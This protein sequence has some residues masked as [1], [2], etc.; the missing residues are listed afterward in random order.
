[1]QKYWCISDKAVGWSENKLRRFEYKLIKAHSSLELGGFKVFY[2]NN[3]TKPL[4]HYSNLPFV[5]YSSHI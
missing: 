4:E 1:M 2:S 5:L 3:E